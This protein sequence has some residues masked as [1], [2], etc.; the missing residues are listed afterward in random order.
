MKKRKVGSSKRLNEKSKNVSYKYPVDLQSKRVFH[1]T[2]LPH[3][4]KIMETGHI[5]PRN[6]IDGSS[7]PEDYYIWSTTCET[8]EVTANKGFH[9]D[10]AG[11]I[12]L[13]D[14]RDT[15]KLGMVRIEV[16]PRFSLMSYEQFKKDSGILRNDARSLEKAGGNPHE[17]LASRIPVSVNDCLVAVEIWHS[18]KWIDFLDLEHA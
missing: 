4:R 12:V 11:K 7:N 18:G 14:I 2:V 5:K 16:E 10:D 8:W 6:L 17:W 13:G 1:Y 9:Y 3:A 15:E